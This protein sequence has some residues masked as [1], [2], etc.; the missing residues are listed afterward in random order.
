MVT[1]SQCLHDLS[2]LK[3][4]LEFCVLKEYF[5]NKS[6]KI[7]VEYIWNGCSDSED[8]NGLADGRSSRDMNPLQKKTAP[9]R[10]QTKEEILQEMNFVLKRALTEIL[11]EVTSEEIQQVIFKRQNMTYTHYGI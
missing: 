7:V 11:L 9:K 4:H 10:T 2:F 3:F 6:H 1:S 8:E 5:R